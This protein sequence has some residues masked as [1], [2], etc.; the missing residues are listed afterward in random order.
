[1]GSLYFRRTTVVKLLG[2]Y[3]P[4]VLPPNHPKV[5]RTFDARP[6]RPLSLRVRFA[7]PL[8]LLRCVVLVHQRA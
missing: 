5:R 7:L 6:V 3:R 2:H 1:M 8:R 4:D